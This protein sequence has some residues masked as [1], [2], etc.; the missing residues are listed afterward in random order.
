MDLDRYQLQAYLKQVVSLPVDLD[1]IHQDPV[2]IIPTLNTKFLELAEAVQAP[3]P[4]VLGHVIARVNHLSNRVQDLFSRPLSEKLLNDLLEIRSRSTLLQQH[5]VKL[6][7]KF[8][9]GL[10]E[11]VYPLPRDI[12][13]KFPI[14]ECSGGSPAPLCT[15][16]VRASEPSLL[17]R[18]VRLAFPVHDQYGT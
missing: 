10:G 9:A 11:N 13:P 4:T 12:R 18:G 17:N 2:G 8:S 16:R 6:Q 14:E 15:G 5:S 7:T 1:R 3:M